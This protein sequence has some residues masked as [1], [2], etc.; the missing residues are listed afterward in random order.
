VLGDHVSAYLAFTYGVDPTPVEAID[1]IKAS[2]AAE[3]RGAL[4]G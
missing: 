2:L 4:S 1:Y 3:D